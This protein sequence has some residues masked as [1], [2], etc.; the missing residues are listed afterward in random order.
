MRVKGN[1]LSKKKPENYAHFK[2]RFL[3]R[4]NHLLVTETACYQKTIALFQTIHTQ[5]HMRTHTQRERER[6]N[7][8][9]KEN[10]SAFL[11]KKEYCS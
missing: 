5:T 1:N 7:T 4:T 11:Q 9:T 6:E 3:R 10:S 2:L 8:H